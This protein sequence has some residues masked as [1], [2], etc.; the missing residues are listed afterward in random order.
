MRPRPSIET[1]RF[2]SFFAHEC[3]PKLVVDA[4]HKHVRMYLVKPIVPEY[5]QVALTECCRHAANKA[6]DDDESSAPPS[7]VLNS[8]TTTPYRQ[9]IRPPYQQ[10]L[11]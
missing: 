1:E 6:L 8:S 10:Q 4:E 11:G 3:D 2:Q 9:R 7:L 5:L